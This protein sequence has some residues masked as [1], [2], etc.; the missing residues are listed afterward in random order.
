M[1]AR[2]SINLLGA[3]RVRLDD[4]S[5]TGFQTNKVR[6]LLA[7]L[8]IEAQRPHQRVYLAG[9]LWPNWP[10]DQ[11]RT[12]LRQA[13]ANLHQVLGRDP[14]S[15]FLLTTRH[16]IQFNLESNHRLDVAE[17]GEL[18]TTSALDERRIGSD[19]IARLQKAVALY[20]GSFLEGFFLDGCAAFE[21]WQLLTRE[22]LQRQ[23][24]EALGRLVQWHEERGA[25]ALAQRY[26]WQ[27]VELEPLLEAGHRQLMQ[28]L[29]HSGE[30]NAALA[31][32]ER[33]RRLLAEELG[34]EPTAETL[35]LVEQIRTNQP[36]GATTPGQT[37]AGVLSAEGASCLPSLPPFLP[38][39]PAS[40]T[41]LTVFVDREAELDQLAAHLKT[42]LNGQGHVVFMAGEAGLGKTT[43]IREFAQRAQADQPNLL[44]VGGHC[45]SHRGVGDPFLPFR[46]ILAQLSGDFETEWMAG[47]ITRDQVRRL[48]A[49]FPHTIEAVL[50]YGP[51]LVGSLLPGAA[52]AGR[53]A[54]LPGGGRAWQVQLEQMIERKKPA[55]GVIA[56][57]QQALFD[58]FTK[59]VQAVAGQRPLLIWLDDLQWGDLDSI[60][61]LFHLGQRLAGQPI[62][63]L[64]AYRPEEVASSRSEGRH[65]LQKVIHELQQRSGPNLVDLS[66][67]EGRHF[68]EAYLDTEPNH[69]DRTFQETL[70]RLSG[71]HPLFTVELLRGMQERGDLVRDAQ[72]YWIEGSTLNWDILPARVEAVIA[73][74]IERLPAEQ[75][76][77][78]AVAGVQ[79]ERFTA[80]VVADV[81]DREPQQVLH[82]LSNELSRRHRLVAARGIQR[83][84]QQ[85]LATY[86]FHH[87][88]YQKYLYDSLDAV[89]RLLRHEEIAR[90]LETLYQSEPQAVATIAGQLAW[91]Y[92]QADIKEKAIIYLGQAGDQAM[93]LSA[94]DEAM[95]SFREGLALLDALPNTSERMQLELDLSLDL[96]M[97]QA[98]TKGDASLEVEQSF[99]RA[100][101]LCRQLGNIPALFRVL[102]HLWKMHFE[103]GE[104]RTAQVV[105]QE[106]LEIAQQAQDPAFLLGAH[107]ALGP[108]LYRLGQMVAAHR[109]LAEAVALFDTQQPDSHIY[110]YGLE[111]GMYCRV[112]ASLVLWYLGSP[113]QAQVRNQEAL[114]RAEAYGHPFTLAF[115]LIFAAALYQRSNNPGPTSKFAEKAIQLSREHQFPLWEAVGTLYH[116]WAVTAQGDI[117]SGLAEARQGAD[118]ILVTGMKHIRYQAVL[119]DV[120]GIAGQVRSAIALLDELLVIIDDTDERE[121]EA[122]LYRLRGDLLLKQ[123]EDK[124]E[125]EAQAHFLRAI[126]VA[127][128]QK[129][130]SLELRATMRLSRLWQRQGKGAAARRQ[131]AELYE[132]FTEGFDTPDLIEAKELLG[133]LSD[134]AQKQ[135]I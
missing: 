29:A 53:L 62:L 135:E 85:R 41:S 71:G 126:K 107:M 116:G 112:N 121:W 50:A 87:A 89:E 129:A 60:A 51:D 68:V 134:E 80:E 16:S 37:S 103:R 32:Y 130:K 27:R 94:L 124:A 93:R 46:E 33:Y 83:I 99:N 108:T 64:G 104:I 66:Q 102:W 79:G 114:A 75:R 19:A 65:P 118:A 119:A 26:A 9:L 63:I 4:K 110:M 101:Q 43:L 84:G 61:L 76:E 2:L 73:E 74:R 54:A 100:H 18:L 95:T 67:A 20:R 115:A 23:V 58:Q 28:L 70:Y 6:A 81:L 117:E 105:A 10:E 86:R 14:A 47:E 25:I 55:F 36:S 78:L 38:A 123:D 77:L 57:P 56:S 1:M 69:L 132:W 44:V 106:C 3:F 91:H 127:C 49:I 21:E 111:P 8:A 72:G 88:L 5:V 122:E 128:Q 15:P 13:L 98:M 42:A 31:H 82:C 109:S 96:G 113:D 120:L 7:Y 34:T 39:R 24:V 22:R 48:W 17:L 12:Y 11:A 59:V 40:S 45:T 133:E 125:I 92:R 97:V 30:G 90:S 131:L 52:L 35:A